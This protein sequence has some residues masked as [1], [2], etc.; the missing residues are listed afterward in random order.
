MRALLGISGTLR[1]TSDCAEA[2]KE[3]RHVHGLADGVLGYPFGPGGAQEGAVALWR[4]ELGCGAGQ[5]VG[6]WSQ[7]DFLTLTR[8]KWDCA[9]GQVILDTHPGGHFIPH[10][11]IARQL[12]E[13]LDLPPRY[14]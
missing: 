13:L 1:R 6:T 8:T 12:D 2:P 5:P 7:V 14:P 11:W 9:E 4:S 3:V 10:G